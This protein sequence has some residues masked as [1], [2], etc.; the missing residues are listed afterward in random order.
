[1][2]VPVFSR[3]SAMFSETKEGFSAKILVDSRTV[4]EKKDFVSTGILTYTEGDV[5]EIEIAEYR[6]FEL[7]DA[8]KITI[9]S[10]VGIFL[11]H[12]TVVAKD[13]G[14][15]IIIHP[16]EHQ[17]KFVE[18]RETTRVDITRNGIIHAVLRDGK[19]TNALSRPLNIEINNISIMGVGFTLAE[20]YDFSDGT[21]LQ[22]HLDLDFELPCVIEVVRRER[23][24]GGTYYGAKIVEMA[25][26]K[27]RSLRAFVLKEQVQSH[28][29]IKKTKNR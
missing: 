9:Y 24:D 20:K 8:V 14:S 25:A 23:A 29:S 21:R 19:P 28:Y 4:V 13:D 2:S 1:M 12:S 7:G 5:I 6:W 18:K 27:L 15:I 3:K 22:I 10:P 16:P 26:D 11:L 17:K